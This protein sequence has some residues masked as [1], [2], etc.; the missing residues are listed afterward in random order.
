MIRRWQRDEMCEV[1]KRRWQEEG[2]HPVTT[3]KTTA[4]GDRAL[5]NFSHTHIHVHN[6]EKFVYRHHT[7]EP[8]IST[9]THS[10]DFSIC[11]LSPSTLA[12]GKMFFLEDKQSENMCF[13][14]WHN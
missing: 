2:T 3:S 8:Y 7:A 13:C 12:K 6:E 1:V 14:W 10:D 5:I 9:V 4:N 11:K